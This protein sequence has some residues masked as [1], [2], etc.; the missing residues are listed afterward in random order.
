MRSN[1]R[2]GTKPPTLEHYSDL[3]RA[4]HRWLMERDEH[5]RKQYFQNKARREGAGK[6]HEA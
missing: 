6:K 4:C 1:E 2:P 3:A 5:Y